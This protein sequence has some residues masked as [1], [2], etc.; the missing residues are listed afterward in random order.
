MKK[1]ITFITLLSILL[2]TGNLFAQVPLLNINE[3]DY[4]QVNIDTSEFIEL[5]NSSSSAIDLGQ[6]RV[7]L[8]NGNG[9]TVYDSIPLPT[10]L[11][12]PSSYFV[13]CGSAGVVPNC[14]MVLPTLSNII[15]NG[16]PDAIALW[17]TLSSTVIDAVSYEGSCPVPYV[18]GIGVPSAQ[19][20]STL[21]YTSIGRYP[22]GTDTDDNSVD[23][24]LQCNTPGTANS[25][26]NT[27]CQS[28]VS[29]NTVLKI[30]N[31]IRVYPN[32]ASEKIF[33]LGNL[34]SH[35]SSVARIYS[36]E[37]KLCFEQTVPD[38]SKGV[39]INIGSLENGIYSVVVSAQDFSAKK[40][41]VIAR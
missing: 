40:L 30:E 10:Y 14:N 3:V 27:N 26:A 33:V 16:A 9:N 24:Y 8:F 4:D 28:P 39:A 17:D 23:F 25:N 6:F 35:S 2:S 11:L 5:Y 12:N 37:G 18:E 13:I 20:D 34:L 41:F 19:S 1:K 32:P 29:T 15:Q 31:G 21:D 36:T 7:L 38:G 22:D